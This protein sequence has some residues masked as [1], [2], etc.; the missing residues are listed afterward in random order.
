VGDVLDPLKY[1]FIYRC[2]TCKD[3]ETKFRDYLLSNITTGVRQLAVHHGKEW[4][5]KSASNRSYKENDDDIVVIPT[6]NRGITGH[7]MSFGRMF[8]ITG[9]HVTRYTLSRLTVTFKMTDDDIKK[10]WDAVTHTVKLITEQCTSLMIK[11]NEEWIDTE[12]DGQRLETEWYDNIHD[13]T[14]KLSVFFKILA[15]LPFFDLGGRYKDVK[16]FYCPFHNNF[17]R[18]LGLCYGNRLYHPF[19]EDFNCE[20]DK[21]QYFCSLEAIMSHCTYQHN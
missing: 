21:D 10:C 1:N 7:G 18:V 20:C 2:L 3:K 12:N 5:Y 6:N 13:Y 9:I 8:H 19:V 15:A 17:R 11:A 4:C 16:K 14:R